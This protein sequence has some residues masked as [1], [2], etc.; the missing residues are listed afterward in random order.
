MKLVEHLEHCF[1]GGGGA[2]W[3]HLFERALKAM[4]R[5]GYERRRYYAVRTI[6]EFGAR[7]RALPASTRR[8]ERMSILG[9]CARQLAFH[10]A[11]F[12]VLGEKI[13]STP[14]PELPAIAAKLDV[15]ADSASGLRDAKG[16]EAIVAELVYELDDDVE[17]NI[18]G[19]K[20]NAR[21]DEEDEIERIRKR[22]DS[23]ARE[24][25]NDLKS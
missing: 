6:R 9:D 16:A 23:D 18:L 20:V 19:I 21:A 24:Y 13:R 22:L 17:H 15:Y 14:R 11:A 3:K 4:E 12:A 25:L 2:E 1:G 10:D 5:G 8:A 7:W